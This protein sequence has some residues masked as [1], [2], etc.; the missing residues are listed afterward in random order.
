MSAREFGEWMVF[1]RQEQLHPAA[2][3]LRHAQQ[4]AAAH[5][6]PLS[7]PDKRLWRSADLMPSDP[8]APPPAPT[9]PAPPG[10]AELAA[11]A[12]A[13]NS[14]MRGREA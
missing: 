14:A 12:A 7:R 10:F 9:P 6:G 13:I 5:N 2:D 11:Q 1:F 4:L 3:R 8:W